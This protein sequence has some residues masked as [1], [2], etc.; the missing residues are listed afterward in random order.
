MS[1][2]TS[3]GAG[4][5]QR[6]LRL[7]TAAALILVLASCV[8]ARASHAATVVARTLV[9]AGAAVEGSTMSVTGRS[10]TRGARYGWARCTPNGRSCSIVRGA[11]T[12]RHAVV[13]ADIGMR[14]KVVATVGRRKVASKLSPVVAPRTPA[15]ATPPTVVG[16]ASVGSTLTAR[17]G[18][19]NAGV[20]PTYLYQ[21][22]RCPAGAA[23]TPIPGATGGSYAVDS[24]ADIGAAFRVSVQARVTVR[25]TSSIGTALSAMTNVVTVSILNTSAPGVAG[26]AVEGATLTAAAG[27]WSASGALPVTTDLQ[28]LRCS[29]VCAPV[30][31]ATGPTYA[32]STIDV[33]TRIALLVTARA[34]GATSAVTS[35]PSEPV[36]A[37]APTLVEVPQVDGASGPRVGAALT[38]S[39]GTWTVPAPSSATV[40]WQR[41]TD[42]NTCTDIPG[43]TALTYSPTDADAAAALRVLVT[44][45]HLGIAVT[46]ASTRTAAVSG[47][48][49]RI[50]TAP[51]V[52][53]N[54]VATLTLTGTV[55]AAI[56]T[57]PVSVSR[58]W[59]RCDAGGGTCQD[60][61]GATGGTYA[62][63]GADLGARIRLTADAVNAWGAATASSTATPVVA[64]A[65]P[66]VSTSPT[67]RAT[68]LRDTM[69]ATAAPGTWTGLTPMQY[70]YG[71]LRCDAAGESCVDI[72]GATAASYVMTTADVA[73]TLRVAVT[74]SN[75]AGTATA[76]SSASAVIDVTPV[77]GNL[78]P[79]GITGT[80]VDKSTLQATPGTWSGLPVG[81]RSYQ[82]L[83]CTDATTC[84]PISTGSGST[85]RLTST[86]VG[87]TI[88]VRE[89]VTNAAG[90]GT[91][92][93]E[94]TGLVAPVAP[95][96]TTA[97]SIKG[98]TR[99][100]DTLTASL[101]SWTGTPVVTYSYQWHRCDAAGA[102]CSDLTGATG[103]SYVART[104]DIGATVQ[105][106]VTARNAAGS[107]LATTA[108]TAIVTMAPPVA[109][110]PAPSV[111]G[112]LAVGGTLRV[113]TGSWTGSQP[114]D[115]AYAW[116]RCTSS[117][118]CGTVAIS[119]G[120]S[121]ELVQADQGSRIRARV[122]A[123]NAAGS[124]P[125]YSG[126]TGLV[127]PVAVA[128]TVQTPP[129]IAGD[130]R[131]GLWIT[132]AP[133]TFA[134]TATIAH[135]F[136]WERCDPDLLACAVIDGATTG[137]YRL[138]GD[139]VGSVV[140]VADTGTNT[141]GSARAV[142][143]ATI[144]I[145]ATAGPQVD[146]GARPTITGALWEDGQLV[147]LDAGTWRGTPTITY[148]YQWQ[149][150]TAEGTACVDIAGATGRTRT[151][152]AD[153]VGHTI[154]G[155]VT[156]TS[157]F[158]TAAAATDVSS[159][160]APARRPVNS[161]SLPT[162]SGE[163]EQSRP[164]L[165]VQGT[166][167]GS[168]MTYTFQWRRCDEY[169]DDCIDVF[170]ATGRQYTPTAADIG[171]TLRLAV[172][173]SNVAAPQG[174]PAVSAETSIVIA[175]TPPT[176]T[177]APVIEV[178]TDETS[179]DVS[180][181]TWVGTRT[182]TV[183]WQWQHCTSTN[184]SSCT[185]WGTPQTSRTYD[186]VGADVDS[187]MRVIGLATNVV[188]TTPVRSTPSNI[189]GPVTL[190]TAPTASSTPPTI[191]G[192]PEEG[193]TLTGKPGT[194]EGI[195][196][197]TYDIT[198]QRCDASGQG[199]SFITA[200]TGPTYTPVAADVSSRLRIRV[201]ASN[202][203]G[204]SVPAYSTPTA[205][206]TA[207]VAPR[208]LDLPVVSGADAV[209]G[210]LLTGANGSWQGTAPI[211]FAPS[212]QRCTLDGVMCSAIPGAT[213][214]T[215]RLVPADAGYSVRVAYR[216]TNTFGAATRVSGD[217][218]A[219]GGG[220]IAA[221]APAVTASPVLTNATVGGATPVVGHTLK[222]TPGTWTG[223]Q[224]IVFSQYTWLR[225]DAAGTEC[226]EV[227]GATGTTYVATVDDVGSTIR[228]SVLAVNAAELPTAA[229]SDAT[230]PVG[231]PVTPTSVQAPTVSDAPERTV[232]ATST[233]GI[234]SGDD[235]IS[236]TR[237]WQRCSSTD[238]SSC[239]DITTATG[240]QY[241]PVD[242]DV[243]SYLRVVVT[244]SN[245]AGSSGSRTAASAMSTNPVSDGTLPSTAGAPQIS[246]PL[247]AGA[248]HEALP[249]AWVG[250]GTITY[251]YQWQRCAA[252][253]TACRDLA[254]RATSKYTP[255]SADAGS[256]LRVVVRGHNAIGVSEPVASAAV[257]P[258]S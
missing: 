132:A 174:V 138:T 67:I 14:L 52:T 6:V 238:V 72:P 241:T 197:I 235:P 85:Y 239:R 2:T 20:R 165:S 142:S 57:A 10:T 1:A 236:F 139:D 251:S 240:V 177:H 258:I 103:S 62:L 194:W 99:E 122:T 130:P 21:W 223:T 34:A 123:T 22:Y 109:A 49:A 154:R 106:T 220:V 28:W 155:R 30:P 78:T 98:T 66:A 228:A 86:D 199:C 5:S 128:P 158:G 198:W 217:Y 134:G 156:A 43:A 126:L 234:W 183:K 172:T 88:T 161:G 221:T 195:G 196:P 24:G 175:A 101:G 201:V 150:C 105:L 168:P 68:S 124:T 246:G 224:P 157:T 50:T 205:V 121:Y 13:A 182:I 162:V 148:A 213:A 79:P 229:W 189:L 75:T 48:P 74:A 11:V 102:S 256:T 237:I 186:I 149:R 129:G 166:W 135:A 231:E 33:G 4:M 58:R 163:P 45:S 100:G 64:M 47:T 232:R 244:A 255:T 214:A 226:L 216:A 192:T 90:S 71:W 143:T 167:S 29:A 111:T 65:A 93:S 84:T 32:L 184:P 107:T 193:A 118:T 147:T 110:S 160:V 18:D 92:Q 151:L 115:H 16:I 146:A 97:P 116:F 25:S 181:D 113:D 152:D 36:V 233:N 39:S 164:L 31:G 119:T 180:D 69:T 176:E 19:W 17:A 81:T 257:G 127:A 227:A 44:V 46:A 80:L 51:S 3:T 133:A 26:A 63:S 23:C 136:T 211:T 83:R 171:T 248:V 145:V 95:A 104:S 170:G 187:Y 210:T 200:A 54:A 73:S 209:V 222:V 87:R 250:T 77:P 55:P 185:D 243:G 212:W 254:G 112:T 12:S 219:A 60:I 215:Y 140:R 38:A 137:S 188:A 191:E 242:L 27:S 94:T 76:R 82:W 42:A 245:G 218:P 190:A 249:G 8:A 153:D 89:T 178:G 159:V 91:S 247:T 40:Q 203:V 252:D 53:G 173:A 108:S 131:Q 56:G 230:A 9:V 96:N 204:S 141:A 202:P 169:G 144:T 179:F 125:V 120:S 61:P 117:G 35:I 225:C 15:V 70:A 253:G 7:A 208:S 41:C 37:T 206:V 114:T 59:Q 207:G